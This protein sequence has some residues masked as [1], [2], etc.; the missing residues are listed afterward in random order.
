MLKRIISAI[1]SAAC[2]L[3]LASC[4]VNESGQSTAEESSAE[5]PET[6][7]VTRLINE[8][9]AE[10]E[11]E[12]AEAEKIYLDASEE[13]FDDLFDFYGNL[14]V[15]HF[16]RKGFSDESASLSYIMPAVK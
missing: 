2:V 6:E 16:L 3:S 15:V 4:G 8:E 14:L 10:S 7:S 5:I 11:T 1:L 9:T 12:T 13:D